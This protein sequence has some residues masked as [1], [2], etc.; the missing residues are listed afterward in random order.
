MVSPTS[1]L[2]AGTSVLATIIPSSITPHAIPG[3]STSAGKSCY[4]RVLVG[5]SFVF[6]HTIFCNPAAVVLSGRS[7]V[8]LSYILQFWEL[9]QLVCC[10]QV[11]K[12]V[13]RTCK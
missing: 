4:V 1:R 5:S 6:V 13:L 12:W 11:F 2:A 8:S 9:V 3:A 7:I 10:K